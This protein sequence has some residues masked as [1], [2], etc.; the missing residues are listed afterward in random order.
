[1]KRNKKPKTY[2]LGVGP[3][4]TEEAHPPKRRQNLARPV[5]P[6]INRIDV[7]NLS[8]GSILSIQELD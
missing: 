8:T 2:I 3:C 1:M 7:S 6:F 4:S 5:S